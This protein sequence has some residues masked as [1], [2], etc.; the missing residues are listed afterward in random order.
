MVGVSVV[1][2][3]HWLVGLRRR[4]LSQYQPRSTGGEAEGEGLD[5]L[6]SRRQRHADLGAGTESLYLSL[7]PVPCPNTK[8]LMYE[9]ER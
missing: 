4:G 3:K 8:I 7:S 5:L 1:D 9:A 2:Q 6:R